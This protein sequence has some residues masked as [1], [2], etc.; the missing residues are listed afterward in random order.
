MSEKSDS[1]HASASVHKH[2]VE[3]NHEV[4]LRLIHDGS[5][6]PARMPI[7]AFAKNICG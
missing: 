7:L 2:S 5:T 6:Y 3:I 1:H 4:R